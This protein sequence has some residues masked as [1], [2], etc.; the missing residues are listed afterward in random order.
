MPRYVRGILFVTLI[1]S[2]SHYW[3]GGQAKNSHVPLI[4]LT[5]YGELA[6]WSPFESI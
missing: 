5:L 3:V 4:P 6:S 1:L 2:P